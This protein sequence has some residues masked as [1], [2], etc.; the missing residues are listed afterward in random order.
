MPRVI[1]SRSLDNQSKGVSA[2]VDSKRQSKVRAVN[3]E[4]ERILN[5][6]PEPDADGIAE[7]LQTLKAKMRGR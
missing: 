7:K 2:M 5:P 4:I 1:T 3:A 6:E